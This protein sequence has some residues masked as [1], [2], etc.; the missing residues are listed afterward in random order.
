MLAALLLAA[1]VEVRATAELR[2]ALAA[3][4]PGTTLRVA[5]GEYEGG[6]AAVG[7]RGTREQPIAIR[8]AD[9]AH[10]PIVRGGVVGLHLSDAE[11]VEVSG[12]VFEGQTG[13]GINIDDGGTFDTPSHGIALR[14][15][16][17]RDIGP[18]GNCD[19]IKLSGVVDFSIEACTIERWG[20]GGSGI[21]LVGCSNGAIERCTLRNPTTRATASGVQAKG[22]S[23]SIR[24]ER[25]LWVCGDALARTRELVQRP[26]NARDDRYGADPLFVDAAE[27]DLHVRDGSP[28]ADIGAHA[29]SGQPP[30]DRARRPR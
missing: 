29:F 5:P 13:N 19:G 20:S 21:D 15:I 6:I 10:P 18:Q 25:N 16:A 12:L 7:L 30:P 9:P 2:A 3:A 4:K 22:G 11:H 1:D 8:A 24:I 23:R 17:V 26:G 14:G 27:F 28:A